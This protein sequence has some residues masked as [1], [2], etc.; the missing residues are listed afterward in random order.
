MDDFGDDTGLSSIR[1]TF[2]GTFSNTATPEAELTVV[3]YT[4][5]RYAI[6]THDNF[7]DFDPGWRIWESDIAFGLLEYGR[8]PATYFSG[9]SIL[10]RTRTDRGDNEYSL[11]GTSPN[12]D[13]RTQD[14]LHRHFHEAPSS[15]FMDI[16]RGGEIN[17]IIDI[18]SSRYNFVID[19]TGFAELYTEL[20]GESWES[21][22]VTITGVPRYGVG[23][24]FRLTVIESSVDGIRAGMGVGIRLSEN[25]DMSFVDD[26][27]PGDIVTFE[28]QVLMG[29]GGTNHTTHGYA[30][31][32]PTLLYLLDATLINH[33]PQN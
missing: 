17:S 24:S 29:R 26:F 14:A 27:S 20:F 21:Q 13:V 31:G 19:G 3:V 18:G 11:I 23:S 5:P 8:T 4:I 32:F 12:G 9:D 25:A 1:G 16:F 28:G 7:A 22:T 30:G 15:V 2:T 33:I 6:F 10:L